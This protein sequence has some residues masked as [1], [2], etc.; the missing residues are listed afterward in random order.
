M[1]EMRKVVT[2]RYQQK[3]K[4]QTI[5]LERKSSKLR[6]ALLLPLGKEKEEQN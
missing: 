6:K 3:H 5:H 4:I 1:L 2:E